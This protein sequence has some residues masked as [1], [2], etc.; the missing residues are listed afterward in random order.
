MKKILTATAVAAALAAGNAQAAGQ[1]S[2]QFNVTI[3][4]T[5]ACTVSTIA[6]VV[7]A[8]TANQAG[9]QAATGGGFTVKCSQTLPYSL[10]LQSGT[11]AG[12]FV[13][14]FS[15]T[16]PSVT[17]SVVNLNYSLGLTAS[18]G[19]V[20]DGTAQPYNVTGSMGALQAGKCALATCDNTGSTNNRHTL[21]VNY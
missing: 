21:I 11:A 10:A 18:T 8:Y 7:F 5:S 16:I 4:L 14:P 13:G 20:A 1:T 2:G 15:A 12:P 3:N 19:L 9:A 17:D 6:D